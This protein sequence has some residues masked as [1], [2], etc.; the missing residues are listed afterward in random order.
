MLGVLPSGHRT[1]AE[2]TSAVN[3][4]EQGFPNLPGHHIPMEIL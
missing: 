2:G 3:W 4:V 1:A